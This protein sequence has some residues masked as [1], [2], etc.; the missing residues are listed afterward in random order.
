MK[1]KTEQ[2]DEQGHQQ[3]QKTMKGIEEDITTANNG[4]THYNLTVLGRMKCFRNN[5]IKR[6]I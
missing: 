4:F 5:E 2:R 6:H 1:L 3:K